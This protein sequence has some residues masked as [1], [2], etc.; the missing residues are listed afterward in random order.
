MSRQSVLALLVSLTI[1]FVG[2]SAP[3]LGGRGALGATFEGA[4]AIVEITNL[5]RSP[6]SV[7][8]FAHLTVSADKEISEIDIRCL[9]LRVNSILSDAIYVDR[10]AHV[11]PGR[12]RANDAGVVNLDVYWVFDDKSLVDADIRSLVLESEEASSTCVQYRPAV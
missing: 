6:G 3:D 7:A 1:L 2:C 9:R 5:K 4:S 11:L 10:V 12:V 8:V